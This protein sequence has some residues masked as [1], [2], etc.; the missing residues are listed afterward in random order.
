MALFP[1]QNRY[2]SGSESSAYNYGGGLSRSGTTSSQ[3]GR[4]IRQSKRLSTTA[5]YMS[6][7]AKDKDV[8]ID[9]ELA[10]GIALKKHE[11]E[12][13]DELTSL[14]PRKHYENSR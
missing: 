5:F 11:K 2:S 9:D 10:R 1:P 7:S 4:S 6:V 8:E 14:Q 12:V 13:L 3:D